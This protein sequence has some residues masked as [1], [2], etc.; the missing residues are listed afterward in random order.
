MNEA[1]NLMKTR[2]CPSPTGNIHM[3]N[4]RTALFCALLA[5]SQHGTLLLRIEDTDLERSKETYTNQLIKDLHWMG[6]DWQEGAEVGGAAGPYWQSQ[7]QTIYNEY[8]RKL[9]QS[10]LVF[11]CFCSTEQ[12]ALSRKLQQAKGQPPRYAG[13][14]RMLTPEQIAEKVGQGMKATLRFRVPR[15]SLIEFDDFVKGKQRFNS[16]D[17][18]DFIIRREDNTATFLFC[19]AIDDALMEVTHVLR[20]EDHLTNTPRQILLLQALGFPIPQYGHISL[21]VG[22]D[23]SPLSKRHGSQSIKEMYTNG[24]L[25]DGVNNYLARLGHYYS[26]TNYMTFEQ[27]VAGF[28]PTNLGK[29]PARFDAEQ[30][31]YWQREAVRHISDDKFWQWLGEEVQQLIPDASH[32]QFITL[33]KPNIT[34]PVDALYWA[35]NF[36]SDSLIYSD[37]AREILKLT[38]GDFF[39]TALKVVDE[40][41]ID[42]N[43]LC[44]ILKAELHIK[45]K[46]LFQPLRIALTGTMQGP[47]LKEIMVLLGTHKVRQRFMQAKELAC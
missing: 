41:N 16:N 21:I 20:G 17:I 43:K 31:L 12:L 13:T 29:A 15:H 33:I 30:L 32:K 44:D 40:F 9:E 24:F 37:E 1:S 8:Y 23:S 5:K 26:E 46:A 42:Y 38:G 47:E 4:A 28:N 22:S 19:N 18:G 10:G 11:P 34:F 25:P 35:K 45:G 2:F 39:L 36:F 27:L 7:R 14:C 3:G 6:I